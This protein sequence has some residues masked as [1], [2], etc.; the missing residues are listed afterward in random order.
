MVARA[1]LYFLVRYPGAI[2]TGKYSASDI[3]MFVNWHKNNKSDVYEWHRNR[4]IYKSQGNCNPFID[5]PE[6][7]EKVDFMA[8]FNIAALISA[9][10]NG[11]PG[12]D[13][14]KE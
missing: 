13:D 2:G 12:P 9:D 11:V 7:V 6:L 3:A 1:V 4:C 14:E 5:F 10:G 8:S